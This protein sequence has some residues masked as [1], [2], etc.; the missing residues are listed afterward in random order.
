MKKQLLFMI[1]MISF[2]LYREQQ[3]EKTLPVTTDTKGGDTILSTLKATNNNTALAEGND[4]NP[5]ASHNT[6]PVAM[7]HR[8]TI[9]SPWLK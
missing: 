2:V 8:R 3:I 6:A 1:L 7:L 4:N 9:N 5:P